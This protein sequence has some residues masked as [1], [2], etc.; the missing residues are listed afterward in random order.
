MAPSP[1][2]APVATH[3]PVSASRSSCC[4]RAE[5]GAPGGLDCDGFWPLGRIMGFLRDHDCACGWAPVPGTG[6]GGAVPDRGSLPPSLPDT[7]PVAHAVEWRA[8]T[9]GSY[10]PRRRH[11]CPV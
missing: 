1:I 4:E 3:H 10:S 11:F 8:L 9:V 7:F 6:K 2:S 5:E